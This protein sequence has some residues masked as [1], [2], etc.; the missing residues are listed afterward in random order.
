MSE[1][2]RLFDAGPDPFGRTWHVQFRW[3]QTG[4]SIRH[5]DTVDV[6]FFINTADGPVEEKVIALPR[7]ALL[8]MANLRGRPLSDPYC[9]RLAAAHLRHM[10]ETSEDME[11]TLVTVSPEELAAY[12][13]ELNSVTVP[14]RG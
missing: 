10:I 7:A 8:D 13:N 6:K 3:L 2:A 5:A 1:Q 14:Q 11:K 12:D 4:I 9:L